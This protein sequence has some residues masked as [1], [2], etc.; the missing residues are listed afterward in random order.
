MTDHGIRDEW[1]TR[2]DEKGERRAGGLSLGEVSWRHFATAWLSNR[3]CTLETIQK[4]SASG[5]RE[6][7][8]RPIATRESRWRPP[9]S[10]ILFLS[11]LHDAPLRYT[12]SSAYV[13]SRCL[14]SDRTIDEEVNVCPARVSFCVFRRIVVINFQFASSRYDFG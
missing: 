10:A 3:Y 9:P 2:K 1:S 11:S 6:R 5:T 7:C 8:L 4:G 12:S 14:L 13:Y